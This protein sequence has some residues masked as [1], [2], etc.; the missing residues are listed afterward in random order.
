MTEL[1]SPE[2]YTGA[3]EATFEQRTALLL[4]VS[5]RNPLVHDALK[6]LRSTGVRGE[7]R[8][9]LEKPGSLNTYAVYERTF[10]PVVDHQINSMLA[11][12]GLADIVGLSATDRNLFVANATMHDADKY[13]EIL[14]LGLR[15]TRD[16]GKVI[17]VGRDVA[18]AALGEFGLVM[19]KEEGNYVLGAIIEQD[20]VLSFH[21]EFDRRLKIP[22]IQSRLAQLDLTPQQREIL[23]ALNSADSV[24]EM[25]RLLART[26][27]FLDEVQED[28]AT[29]T[30]RQ[31]SQ[32]I[33]DRGELP[34]AVGDTTD[35]MALL[36]LH[37][38][39]LS[40]YSSSHKAH[41][42]GLVEKRIRD[43]VARGAYTEL[44][45][46]YKARY[47]VGY[48]DLALATQQAT[49]RIIRQRGIEIGT[50]DEGVTPEQIP[51]AIF[52]QLQDRV[53]RFKPNRLPS[54]TQSTV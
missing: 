39:T 20:S 10:D 53:D 14:A 12:D 3:L 35:L 22:L 38:D 13:L 23:I 18:V 19:D 6:T 44:D 34:E 49:E 7:G 43:I 29:Q 52:Q 11:A 8:L 33:A 28:E 2:E 48:W 36:T 5:H 9:T 47:G 15:A 4:A 25:P 42:I 31:Y 37:C 41:T 16:K 21:N 30:V 24:G 54:I 26:L 40:V 51:M 17:T 45:T 27:A 46:E 32:T 1:P 50:I